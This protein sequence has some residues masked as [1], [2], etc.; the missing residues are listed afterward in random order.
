MSRRTLSLKRES[1]AEL[2]A[3][4]LANVAG[5]AGTTPVNQCLGISFEFTC[6]DCVTRRGCVVAT[7]DGC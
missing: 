4:D 3:A 5:A 6:L 1:L 2:G 7:L